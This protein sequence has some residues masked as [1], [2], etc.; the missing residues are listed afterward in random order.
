MSDQAQ[1]SLGLM[2][3]GKMGGAIVQAALRAGVATPER[4]LLFDRFAERAQALAEA[5]GG[6][7]VTSGHQLAQEASHIVLA[8]KPQDAPKALDKLEWPEAEPRLLMSIVAGLR[9]TTLRAWVPDTVELVRAMP[10]T[11]ALIGQGV[12][13][14]LAPSSH[15]LEQARILFEACGA[16]V[17]LDKEELFDALTALSGSGPAYIFVAIEALADGGVRMGLPRATALELATR[18][19]LGAA[20]LVTE[21]GRH[22]AQLK[23]DVA[24]PGGTTIAGLAALEHNGFRSALIEAVTAATT[25]GQQ[26]GA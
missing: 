23:D 19:V 2:G 18:T 12:T 4:L 6:R 20:A 16:V 17:V 11:P 24:S 7:A 3:C 8:V 26:L 5:T 13:G 25:R 21:T 9:L 14:I 1:G 22:P 15:H 10:N